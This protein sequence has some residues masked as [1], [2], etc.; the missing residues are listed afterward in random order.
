MRDNLHFDAQTKLKAGIDKVAKAVGSTMGT[1][2]NNAIIEAI[3]TPGYLTTNDGYSI[4]NAVLLADPIENLGKQILLESINRANK[5]SGD[6]SSTTC[7][8][9]AAII[10]EGLKH[11][12]DHHPM[13]I[14]R[15][16]EA[17]LPLIE[18]SLDTQTENLVK[19]DG[20]FNVERL[21]Q[22]ATISAEDEEIGGTIADIYKEI[23][24]KGIV[25][26]DVSKTGADHYTIGSGITVEGAT[27][28]SP[29]MCDATE[30]GQNTN[31]IRIKNPYILLTKQKLS[32]AAD[33][34]T[35][36]RA[37][38]EKDIKDLVV[39]VDDF[40]PLIVNDLILTR[41]KKGFRI[42]L[43]KMPVLWKDLWYEDL[44]VAT[45]ARVVDAAAGFPMKDLQF[46]HLGQVKNILIDKQDTFLDGIKDVTGHIN[47]LD[48]S[49]D[50][51]LRKARLNTKTARYFVGAQTESALSYRRLKVEDAIAAAYQ[52]LNGGIVAGGGVAL[53][54]VTM[55]LP[56][57]VGGLILKESLKAPVKQITANAGKKLDVD[58]FVSD[59]KRKNT[60]GMNSKSGEIVDM[61]ELGIV[62]PKN[63]VLNAV[64][65]AISVAATV[66]TAPTIVTLPREENSHEP[67]PNLVVK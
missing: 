51:E 45:G 59:P 44:S 14:K 66:L 27:F 13:D 48:D 32:S 49:E 65:N 28:V 17:C 58:G 38:F 55:S 67:H 25:Y 6:G 63:V 35:I 22:V 52:A 56:A 4:A 46:E 11:T 60:Y 15:S 3:E 26:W 53:L 12:A 30:T 33:F 24:Q 5:A 9:T 47:T 54:N 21:K 62:D 37:L 18:E 1:G 50:S 34:D 31:A 41:A 19:E 40:E 2:G 10:E 23:G 61:F 42:V 8:T 16:L 43:V 7:V 20:T 57:T 39:F 64:K 36:A 29:Y